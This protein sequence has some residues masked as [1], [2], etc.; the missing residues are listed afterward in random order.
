MKD[1]QSDYRSTLFK[2]T[3]SINETDDAVALEFRNIDGLAHELVDLIESE[4]DCCSFLSFNL[5]FTKSDPLFLEI[6]S[7]SP[8]RFPLGDVRKWIEQLIN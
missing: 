1:K 7:D 3:I 6:G 5:R 8:D 2:K 4:K